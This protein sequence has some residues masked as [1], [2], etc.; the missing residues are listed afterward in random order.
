VLLRAGA[1]DVHLELYD[2]THAGIEYRYPGGLRYLA[3]RLR[4]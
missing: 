3:D 2:A 1:P 4:T